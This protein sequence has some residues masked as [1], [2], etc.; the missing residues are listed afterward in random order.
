[1]VSSTILLLNRYSLHVGR[2]CHRGVWNRQS[3]ILSILTSDTYVIYLTYAYVYTHV[4][5]DLC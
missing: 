4:Y 3:D 5:D 2:G 1:M